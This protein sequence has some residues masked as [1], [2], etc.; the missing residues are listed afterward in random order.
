M[1]ENPFFC[2][3][4][5]GSFVRSA[6]F[7]L[8]IANRPTACASA[9]GQPVSYQHFTRKAKT[10]FYTNFRRALAGQLRARVGRI[11]H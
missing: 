1:V 11:I 2:G 3:T 4:A 9:A 7:F 8:V 10:G 5:K 6:C